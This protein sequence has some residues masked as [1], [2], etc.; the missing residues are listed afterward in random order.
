MHHHV[1]ICDAVLWLQILVDDTMVQ[2]CLSRFSISATFFCY[3]LKHHTAQNLSKWPSFMKKWKAALFLYIFLSW[4]H[5]CTE[6]ECSL[7]CLVFSPALLSSAALLMISSITITTVSLQH[8][9][10]KP[11]FQSPWHQPPGNSLR[12][13][14]V[15]AVVWRQ[16]ALV[17]LWCINTWIMFGC[18]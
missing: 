11:P 5:L 13:I 1:A 15:T 10:S 4:S 16:S 3:F 8:P 18:L 6:L 9:L 7:L 2:T 17:S 12:A 14:D